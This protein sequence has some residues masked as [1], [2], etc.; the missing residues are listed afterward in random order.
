[1]LC[2]IR[3][4]NVDPIKSRKL[5]LQSLSP[6]T[7]DSGCNL[8]EIVRGRPFCDE[9]AWTRVTPVERPEDWIREGQEPMCR[10][11]KEGKNETDA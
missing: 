11:Q 7:C 2:N 6:D 9:K 1:M 10:E 5:K 8:E 4:K 3:L